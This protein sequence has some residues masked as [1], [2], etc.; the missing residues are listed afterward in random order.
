MA[1]GKKS[2]R[3]PAKEKK[4]EKEQGAVTTAR[5]EGGGLVYFMGSLL[6]LGI[7]YPLFES[8]SFHGALLNALLSIVLLTGV[9]A[10]SFD[11]KKLAAG[12]LF[13]F[14]ALA[15][16]WLNLLAFGGGHH[17]IGLLAS[18]SFTLFYAFTAA[19]ILSFVI[20]EK[21]VRT[22]TLMGAV[23][24]YILIGLIWSS[25]YGLVY[26]F[27]DK[28][29]YSVPAKGTGGLNWADFLY[30]SFATLT[31]AGFGDIMAVSSFAR[32]LSIM[33]AVFGLF[34]MAV[35]VARLVGLYT[36]PRK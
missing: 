21:R 15:F 16:N 8:S 7:A 31:S 33:E 27:D 24:A 32:A 4:A 25:V 28:S 9:Y 19:S 12:V 5:K 13:A 30:Y 34:Y 23:C 6:L 2:F 3:K 22:E 14:P 17:V 29:F 10:V 11:R 26:A 35:L 36:A 1:K 20:R 18:V